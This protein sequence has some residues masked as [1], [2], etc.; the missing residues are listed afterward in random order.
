MTRRRN[1]IN[2]GVGRARHVLVHEKRLVVFTVARERS[3]MDV[4]ELESNYGLNSGTLVTLRSHFVRP[5]YRDR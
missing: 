1:A 5:A 4:M 2:D 3:I